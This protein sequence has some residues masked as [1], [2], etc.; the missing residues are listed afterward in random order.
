MEW[1]NILIGIIGVIGGVGGIVSLYHA[2]SNKDTIDINNMKKM[3]DA[4]KELHEQVVFD[5]DAIKKEFEDYKTSNM[6]YI[7]DF[8][9]R[10]GNLEKRLDLAEGDILL[11]KKNILIAYRCSYP[12]NIQDCPVIKEYE[13]TQKK[14]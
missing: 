4:A 8:K 12:P 13:R 2:K 6:K 14:N 9:V 11:L 1:Y 7:A 5:K 10:F 3:L